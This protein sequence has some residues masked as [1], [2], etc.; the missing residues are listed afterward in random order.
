M[1]S[2]PT[3]SDA[4]DLSQSKLPTETLYLFVDL[5]ESGDD[6]NQNTLGFEPNRFEPKCLQMKIIILKIMT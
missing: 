3:N 6:E 1:G 2:T 5:E 4:E